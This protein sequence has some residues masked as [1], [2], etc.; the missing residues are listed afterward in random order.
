MIRKLLP[1]S[2]RR[3]FLAR[4]EPFVCGTGQISYSQE[5]EDAVLAKLFGLEEGRAP[6]F[7]VD[8]GAHHPTRYSN[9]Y[10]FYRRG[11][12]GL[13]IDAKPGSM[14]AFNL[15][16]PRD[17]NVE[18]AVS[19]SAREVTYF[20]FDEPAI[21]GLDER[22]AAT[23]DGA[24][25][26]I[27]SRTPM[28]AVTLASLLTQH[29]GE[30]QPIDFLN[31]DVE[32]H[33]CSVLRSNDWSRFRP[34]VVL[35]EDAEVDILLLAGESGVVKTMRDVGYTLFARTVLTL[36]FVEDGAIERTPLGVRVRSAT[37][38]AR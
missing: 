14:A 37:R 38:G 10:F 4:L 28:R 21:N 11:W 8:V 32:G 16:R 34:R 33:E 1:R 3:K 20:E 26:R 15:L 24:G 2:F 25:R 5:G 9:T 30:A 23:R 13:N 27:I 35:A 7:Y 17:K 31:V 29:V 6:G 22:L 12:H 19:D 36:I 18:A